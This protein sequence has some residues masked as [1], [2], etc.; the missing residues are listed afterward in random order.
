MYNARAVER[1]SETGQQ[2]SD[3]V[4]GYCHRHSSSWLSKQGGCLDSSENRRDHQPARAEL[5][6]RY[7]HSC[8][9]GDSAA[10]KVKEKAR[11]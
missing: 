11:G 10:H 1:P 6:C 7:L 8:F 2:R 9:R 3:Y 5:P 4:D